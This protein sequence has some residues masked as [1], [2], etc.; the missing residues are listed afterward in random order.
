MGLSTNVLWHQTDFDGLRSIISNMSFACS[1]SLETIMW[2]GS[3]LRMAFPMISFCDIPFSD[4]SEYLT[5]KDG[6]ITGKY[7]MYTIGLKRSWGKINRL[8][9]VWYRDKD[10]ASLRYQKEIYDIFKDKEFEEYGE[11][12]RF[13]WHVTANTKNID[14]KLKKRRFDSYRFYDER[15]F[16]Y[17]P[18]F[19]S[20]IENGLK[21]TI[22]EEEYETYK[23]NHDGRSLIA[24]LTISFT[25]A[26]I[27]YILVSNSNRIND[28]KRLFGKEKCSKIL[29]IS[30]GQIMHDVIGIGH[31]REL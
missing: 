22:S 6:S 31:N 2:K 1:Y 28:V 17:V 25:I 18:T 3:E 19:N 5:N 24:D 10:S 4:M 15:E 26:D 14:G 30:Y 9:P 21:P 29:F 7:G 11:E 23:E 20:L 16:R 12:E 27:A 8:S 13:L